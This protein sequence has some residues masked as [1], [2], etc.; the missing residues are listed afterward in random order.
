MY[1]HTQHII[2][3]FFL[4]VKKNCENPSQCNKFTII[5]CKP[6]MRK[7]EKKPIHRNRVRNTSNK[8]YMKDVGD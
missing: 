7:S 8:N 2:S 4:S 6:I 1:V 3:I 5:L